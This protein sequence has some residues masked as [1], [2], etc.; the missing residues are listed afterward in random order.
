MS[1]TSA[2][3]RTRRRRCPAAPA[4]ANTNRL[5]H[6]HD[7]LIRRPIPMLFYILTFQTLQLKK[8]GFRL[9]DQMFEFSNRRISSR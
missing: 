5:I 8:I 2:M 4:F 9:Y 1:P 6:I 3:N 7:Y